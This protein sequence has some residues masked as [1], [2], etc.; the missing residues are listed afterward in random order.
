MA[1]KEQII[2][3]LDSLSEQNL[4]AILENIRQIKSSQQND[5]YQRLYQFTQQPLPDNTPLLSDEAISRETI[6]TREDEQL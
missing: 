4:E 1:I 2:Q 5:W 3:E 6:Y